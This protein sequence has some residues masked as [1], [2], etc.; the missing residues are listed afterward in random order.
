METVGSVLRAWLQVLDPDSEHRVTEM[1][2]GRYLRSL[3]CPYD[4]TKL[5]DELDTEKLGDLT[6]QAIDVDEDVLWDNFIK[7]SIRA[8]PEGIEDFFQSTLFGS[9]S[10]HEESEEP[11]DLSRAKVGLEQFLDTIQGGG[12]EGGSEQKLFDAISADRTYIVPSEMQWL[13]LEIKRNRRKARAK[14]IAAQDVRV[15]LKSRYDPKESLQQFLQLIKQKN[16]GNM[17]RAFRRSLGAGDNLTLQK[18]M[19]LK[20][21]AELGWKRNVKEMWQMMDKDCSG[22]VTV[23][24]LDYTNAENLAKFSQWISSK[25]GSA[26][27]AFAV[28]D[29]DGSVGISETEFLEAVKAHGFPSADKHLF[30]AIDL[31]NRKRVMLEDMHFLDKWKPR[32][33]LQASPNPRAAAEVKARFLAK[34][35]SFLRAW[36][37]GLDKDGSNQCN[38][39]EFRDACRQIGYKEDVPG[40][41]RAMDHNLIG[42]I[43]LEDLD[44]G[45]D[46]ALQEFRNWAR[47]E[48]GSV[49]CLF[50]TFDDDDSGEISFA[51]FKKSCRIFG[52]RGMLKPI[53]QALDSSGGSG[54]SIGEVV[55]L[56]NWSEQTSRSAEPPDP[57]R[58]EEEKK[59]K[60]PLIGEDPEDRGD[61]LHGLVQTLASSQWQ[62]GELHPAFRSWANSRRKQPVR[63]TDGSLPALALQVDLGSPHV[64]KR[65]ILLLAPVPLPGSQSARNPREEE[66]DRYMAP[67]DGFLTERGR[68]RRHYNDRKHKPSLDALL[69]PT[70]MPKFARDKSQ[71]SL[72]EG[73]SDNYL[74]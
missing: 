47:S 44:P 18:A 26:A 1:T 70:R 66:L 49:K 48:F 28:L 2:F 67:E 55:F 7:F 65:P 56:D 41:W 54:L 52:F 72:A 33:F 22:S 17:I 15:Y 37:N 59:K 45:A 20:A 58:E 9:D 36:R 74:D 60:L 63:K 10:E 34:Y 57:A 51:E 16:G 24:E 50:L 61:P 71:R 13:D 53:F 32:A 64:A 4:P 21:C 29:L 27:N 69:S 68:R 11:E 62:T 42:N 25:F 31:E 8:F 12:W 19:F 3:H 73:D 46:R 30:M 6:L 43:S 23:E 40:A 14:Q 38:W 5:W 35:K 39:D